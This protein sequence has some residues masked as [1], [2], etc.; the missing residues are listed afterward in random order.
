MTRFV[1][2]SGLPASGKST[3]GHVI[4]SGLGL[5]LIDKDVI[6]ESLFDD[7]TPTRPQQRSELSRIADAAFQ[8]QAL[9]SAGAV[10]VSWWKHPHSVEDSGTPTQWLNGLP[11]AVVEVHC[12]CT[13]AVAASRFRARKRHPGHLDGKR[14]LAEL[15]VKFNE[16][17]T[18]GPLGVGSLVQVRTDGAVSKSTLLRQV[19]NAFK[20]TFHA[21]PLA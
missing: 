15:L 16:H 12:L 17:A 3:V 6:L 8:S 1:L 2:L 21:Q 4:A 13:P 19:N 9:A 11:G 5:S 18:H 14:S 20:A 7:V 10:L